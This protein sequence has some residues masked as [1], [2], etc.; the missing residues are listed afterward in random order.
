MDYK[1]SNLLVLI[2]FVGASITA[3]SQ[4]TTI[5]D[6]LPLLDTLTNKVQTL[7]ADSVYDLQAQSVHRIDTLQV[8]DSI[9]AL[10][11]SLAT[12]ARLADSLLMAATVT[13]EEPLDDTLDI[14]TDSIWLNDA[15]FNSLLV[16][17]SYEDMLEIHYTSILAVDE[18]LHFNVYRYR[19]YIEDKV[20]P[21]IYKEVI[22]SEGDIKALDQGVEINDDPFDSDLLD[23][24]SQA[25]SYIANED[26][27]LITTTWNQLPDPPKA[28]KVGIIYNVDLDMSVINK[29]SRKMS[30]PEKIIKQQHTTSPWTKKLVTTVTASQTAFSN[31]SSGGENQFSISADAIAELN[32]ASANKKTQWSNNCEVRLGYINQE[33]QPFVKNLDLFR[34]NS[35]FAQSAFNDWYYA[36]N[37][38]FTSQFFDGFDISS[39]NY[40]DPTSA[41]LSPAYLTIGLGL[42]YKY[43]TK[44]QSKLLSIQA[45]PLSYK[46]TLVTD[47][48]RIDQTNYGVDED[49][50]SRQEVGG[51][52]QIISEYSI[53]DRLAARSKILFFSNYTEN[54]ENIDIN[55]STTITY[56]F[57]RIFALTFTFDLVYDDDIDILL[58]EADDGTQTYGKRLQVKEYMGL[59][60]TYKFF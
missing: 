47:T 52:L 59:A 19:P 58:S 28:E 37:T 57:S 24:L 3:Q 25:R 20:N 32:Y 56:D 21:F 45:S 16:I 1:L 43:T 6:T 53:D 38:E 30:K 10:N 15:T 26:P 4:I 13:H 35:Q 60:L 44:E 29:N 5:P 42:D 2:F 34:I 22:F 55:W 23:V 39:D 51:S 12:V 17:P 31:W 54:P 48:A 11:D 7:T 41:I 36:L 9:A 50:L 14:S 8:S 33:D 27:E 49:K 18:R 40:E 46:M